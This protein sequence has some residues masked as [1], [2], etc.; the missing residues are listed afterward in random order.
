ML[1]PLHDHAALRGGNGD[2]H[3]EQALVGGH[4]RLYEAGDAPERAE[5]DLRNGAGAHLALEF[6]RHLERLDGRRAGDI[7]A[8]HIGPVGKHHSL[9]LRQVSHV[10]DAFLG[11]VEVVERLAVGGIEH[12]E[13]E[14]LLQRGGLAVGKIAAVA[15]EDLAADDLEL[16]DDRVV[17]RLEEASE[18]GDALAR[19]VGRAGAAVDRVHAAAARAIDAVAVDAQG[20]V[21]FLQRLVGL[22]KRDAPL[23]RSAR[24]VDAV[25][26]EVAEVHLI[27]VENRLV[28]A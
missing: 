9:R 22:G 23:D 14:G 15:R 5:A 18:V 10:G 16:G 27:A 4:A 2:R 12:H 28:V 19:P 25:H 1:L 8:V 13:A 20:S 21:G 6:D 7:E 3:V 24:Q 11:L 17:A 26:A